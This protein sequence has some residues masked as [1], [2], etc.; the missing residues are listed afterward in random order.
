[1]A[2]SN[3][4]DTANYF[5]VAASPVTVVPLTLA[6]WANLANTTGGFALLNVGAKAADEYFALA[7]E[8]GVGGDPIRAEIGTSN[9][10]GS[11]SVDT[12]GGF[13]ANVWTHCAGVFSSI[14]INGTTA[15]ING[16]GTTGPVSTSGTPSGVDQTSVGAYEAGGGVFGALNGLVAEAAVWN[17]ALTAADVASLATGVSPMLVRPDALVAYWPLWGAHSPEADLKGTRALVM[18]G[19]MAKADHCRI[20]QPAGRRVALDLEA[21]APPAGQPAIKR[22]GGVQFGVGPFQT[23]QGMRGW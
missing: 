10:T 3:T 6:C 20:F 18:V 4:A 16:T 19:S 13:S 11:R 9:G 14:G 2:R 21:G 8:G 22:M 5:Q 15:Y 7:A 12:A 17:V 1:M 23:C